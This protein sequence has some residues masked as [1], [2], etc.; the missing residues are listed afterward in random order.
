MTI[1][2]EAVTGHRGVPSL[3]PENTLGGFRKAAELGVKWVELDVTALA[4]GTP[5]VNHDASIDRC[6]DGS[7]LLREMLPAQLQGV[8]NAKLYPDWPMEP[9]PLLSDTLVL[10]HQLGLGLNLE[11]KGHG[12]APERL[13]PEVVALLRREFLVG[14]GDLQRLLISSFELDMLEECQRIAP[15]IRRGLLVSDLPADWQRQAE[16]VGAYSLHCDWHH[17][18]QSRVSRIRE[19]GYRLHCW[20]ANVPEQIESL[21]HW[22]LDCVITDNPQDFLR[23]K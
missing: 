16:R 9:I 23:L 1:S 20:T 18:S 17:L 2:A 6:S 7:G 10:L 19:A 12:V 3:A 5:V 8:N 22:G 14:E 15:E 13:V 21:W 4:D 11:L